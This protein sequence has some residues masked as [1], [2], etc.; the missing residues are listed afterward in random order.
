VNHTSQERFYIKIKEYLLP[1]VLFC[2]IFLP[3][4][5]F[6]QQNILDHTIALP[7]QNNTIYLI[8]NQISRQTGYFF[9][10]DSELIDSDR[11]VRI[12]KT[13]TTLGPFLNVLLE[14][15]TLD[16][17]VIEK[18]IL[19]YRESRKNEQIA[20]NITTVDQEPDF[21]IIQGKV[22]DHDTGSPLAFASVGIPTKGLGVPANTDGVFRFKIPAI[23]LEDS[24]RVSYMGYRTRY[25]PM[26][27]LTNNYVE[28]RLQTDYISIQEVI[29]RYFDPLW[30]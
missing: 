24:L 6:S 22:L 18:H 11:R 26:Q 27:L 7:R 29:I 5:L 12:P 9:I 20:E 25:L 17:K 16:F 21:Y 2:L 30:R 3:G 15:P 10:Y 4:H 28:I 8:L 13:E 19:I 23:L 14:D 1:G